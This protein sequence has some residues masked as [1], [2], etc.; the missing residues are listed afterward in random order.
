MAPTDSILLLFQLHPFP[1]PFTQTHFLLP[2]PV[3]QIL[4]ISSSTEPLSVELSAVNLLVCH[5]INSIYFCKLYGVLK[6]ELNSDCLGLLYMQDFE[7]HDPLQNGDHTA[8]RDNTPSPGQLVPGVLTP[9]FHQ[10]CFLLECIQLGG[11]HQARHQLN[12]HLSFLLATTKR[13]HA[14]IRLCQLS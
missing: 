14:Y 8:V 10:L 13:T 11:F 6:R 2:D 7:S 9:S 5:H 3:N 1:L 12:L 4:A